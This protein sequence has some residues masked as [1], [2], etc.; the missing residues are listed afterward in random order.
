VFKTARNWS[1]KKIVAT[2]LMVMMGFLVVFSIVALGLS[3]V[4]EIS[5]S[6][7]G[8]IDIE[9][10]PSIFGLFLWVMVGI[11]LFEAVKMYT[12]DHAVHVETILI[13]GIIAISNHIIAT[14]LIVAPP[15]NLFAMSAILVALSSGYFLVK[16]SH[17]GI[18]RQGHDSKEKQGGQL[19]MT[20]S[21]SNVSHALDSREAQDH[22]KNHP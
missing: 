13:V 2:V 17:F 8:L 1:F 6:H 4:E 18:E 5:S 10:L 9:R 21:H 3:I 12:L 20:Q 11:E 22:I 16:K 15:I 19:A 14:D 7:S